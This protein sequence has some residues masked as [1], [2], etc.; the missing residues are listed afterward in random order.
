MIFE[1]LSMS[2]PS[3]A[4]F[5]SIHNMCVWM[6]DAFGTDEMRAAR[7][8]GAVSME[9]IYSYCLT[10]PGSGS[11]VANNTMTAT[12]DGDHYILNG[13]KT[14]ISNGGIAD[15]STTTR[16]RRRQRDGVVV[17]DDDHACTST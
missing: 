12:P 1:A 17:G 9:D 5:L 10:E 14:W 6:I 11:D 4:A 8:P 15:V 2:C 3:V 7:L 13:K 16:L